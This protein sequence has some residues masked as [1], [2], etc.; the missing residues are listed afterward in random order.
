MAGSNGGNGYRIVILWSGGRRSAKYVH[1]IIA[2]LFIR[3][4]MTGETV[5][6]IDGDKLNNAVANLEWCSM[7]AN[8]R[9][10]RQIGLNKSMP[11]G[12][13][14]GVAHSGCKMT[15]EQVL[16]ARARRAAGERPCDLARSYGMTP[17]GISKI[18]L[19]KK[20]VIG[21]SD[22]SEKPRQIRA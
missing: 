2:S 12:R 9:H 19:G 18:L 20:R 1:R 7:G 15:D 8:L 16:E 17:G 10:A 6:H 13:G 14:T 5:N 3:E 21:P 11:P 22:S 4:P